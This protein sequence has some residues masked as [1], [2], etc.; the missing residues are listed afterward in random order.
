MLGLLHCLCGIA[1][2]L[3]GQG[4]SQHGPS[5]HTAVIAKSRPP[6]VLVAARA[7]DW[8][9]R[10]CMLSSPAEHGCGAAGSGAGVRGAVDEDERRC[11][12]AC[13]PAAQLRLALR[14]DV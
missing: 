3:A 6:P 13:A 1:C 8:P 7:T 4:T 2:L 12:A 14:I 9:A 11:A 10:T 5:L